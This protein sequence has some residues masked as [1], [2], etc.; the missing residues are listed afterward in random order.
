MSDLNNISVIITG[1]SKG[2]GKSIATYLFGKGANIIICSRN[3]DDIAAT[4]K[5]I[6]PEERRCLGV[7]ADVSVSSDAK[8]VIDCALS[9]FGRID[10]LIN[11]AG[12]IGE[13][14]LFENS[15]LV[16]WEDT[17]MTNVLG[18]VNCSHSVIEEMKK[19]K[20]GT[21]INFAGAGVGGKSPLTHFASYVTSKMAVVGFTEVIA[22]ELRDY[23]ITVNAIAPGAINSNITEYILREGVEKVGEAMYKKTLV[24]KENGGDSLEN[25]F[26]LI[27]F[28][29]SGESRNVTGKL[30]SAKWDTLQVLKN[31]EDGSNL[32]TLR[33]IDNELFYGK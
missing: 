12:T 2:I 5:E 17:I 23:N 24:Q 20:R 8:K 19:N 30:L 18:T 14:N 26:S 10:V 21:I 28:L 16:K 1:G 29:I 7:A 6:D 3:H 13:A 22:S 11:N 4:C 32:F 15:D 27:D 25:V 33:R 31:L 9:H